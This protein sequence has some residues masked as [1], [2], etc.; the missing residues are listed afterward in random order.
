M[1]TWGRNYNTGEW[2]EVD[3]DTNGFN[4][5]VMLTTL[6]QVLLL[7]RGE[8]PFYG[9]YGI[10]AQQSVITDIVPDYYVTLTQQQFA[11]FFASLIITRRP[12]S[13]TGPTNPPVYDVNVITNS[14]AIL[15]DSVTAPI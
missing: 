9:D 5:A 4:D 14:G 10:P 6:A 7:N 11:P 8:S 1:R 3:T 15:A 13:G 12:N 2:I